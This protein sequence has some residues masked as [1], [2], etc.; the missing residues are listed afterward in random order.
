MGSLSRLLQRAPSED[1]CALWL[2]LS[3]IPPPHQYLK[4]QTLHVH[5]RKDAAS[6]P[7][8]LTWDGNAP[9]WETET[10]MRIHTFK[11]NHLIHLAHNE[12]ASFVQ[13]LLN[14]YDKQKSSEIQLSR[15]PVI[16][17]ALI[18][19]QLLNATKYFCFKTLFNQKAKSCS[20]RVSLFKTIVG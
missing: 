14:K 1:L 4:R 2:E 20:F 18:I 5:E 6:D 10:Q 3:G 11:A 12:W 13:E 7:A 8:D 16:I 15:V 17:S 9:I 19:L